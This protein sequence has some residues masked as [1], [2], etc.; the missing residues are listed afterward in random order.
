LADPI[1]ARR[2]AGQDH[3][4]AV[5]EIVPEV[6]CASLQRQP[7]PPKAIALYNRAMSTFFSERFGVDSATLEKYGAF[8]ISILTD[9]PLFID[10][11]LLF[12]SR[13]KKYKEL[14]D[15]IV[16]YLIFLRD[17]ARTGSIGDGLLHAWYCFP[18]VE[19]N[20][21]GFSK[22]GNAGHGLGIG[23]A[24][25]LHESLGTLFLDLGTEQ[26]TRGTHLEKVCLIRE[27]VGRD[28]I[29]DFVTNLIKGFLCSYTEKFALSHISSE[30]LRPVPIQGA[31]FNYETET[32]ET[33][34]YTLPWSERDFVLL[35]PKDLLT[36]DENWIN[37]HDLIRQF[38]KIPTAIPNAQ[39]RE[40]VTNYF[41]KLLQRPRRKAPTTAQHDAAAAR[42]IREFPFLIDY[43]IKYKEQSG[44]DAE[45]ISSKKVFDSQVLFIAQVKELQR[46]LSLETTFYLEEG[47]T[48]HEA[49]TRLLYL[50]DAIENKGCHRLFYVAGQPIKREADLQIMY[51]LVWI[52]TQSDVTTEANDGR[53]PADFKI[54]RGALDKTIVEMKLASNSHLRHNLQKQA[55]IYMKASDAKKSLKA[56]LFFTREEELK[57]TKILKQLNLEKDNSIVLI[58]ARPDNK[59]SGSKAR[60]SS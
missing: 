4:A 59:P 42:T 15:S 60:A 55:D 17:K 48:Y 26:I 45:R 13:K 21:L 24:R 38:E 12:N 36:R 34:T 23:F 40:Q 25:A 41:E 43:Y 20:W 14:H 1:P 47:N 37:R 46:T 39:L 29:S 33:V 8:D 7:F 35:T 51:R 44:G 52:G 5:T 18:E 27:G 2:L 31:R 6:Y 22:T 49:R 32:W 16:D 30:L 54:S 50:K 9:L 53:G 57:V 19:Q 3:E 28:N 56:I 11:F 10:P 58:D